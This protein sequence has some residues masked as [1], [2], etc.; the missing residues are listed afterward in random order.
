MAGDSK[1]VLGR[2]GMRTKLNAAHT[3]ARSGASTII[4][5]GRRP[6]ALLQ[7]ARGEAIGSLLTPADGVMTASKRWIAGQL[8]LHGNI[9]HDAG[10]ARDLRETSRIL[11]PVGMVRVDGHFAPRAP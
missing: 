2:G 6:D 8:Q 10:A 9:H 11:L 7:S 5:H 4:A 1:G 3:A